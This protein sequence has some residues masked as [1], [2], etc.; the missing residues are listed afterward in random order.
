[1]RLLRDTGELA[2]GTDA[3]GVSYARGVWMNGPVAAVVRVAVI[4]GGFVGHMRN[5]V[6]LCACTGTAAGRGAVAVT[7]VVVMATPWRKFLFLKKWLP[8]D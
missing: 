2:V 6:R 3:T 8:G 1:M 5:C 7:T 4:G